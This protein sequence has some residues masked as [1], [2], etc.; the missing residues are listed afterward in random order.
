[1]IRQTVGNNC[2]SLFLSFFATNLTYQCLL[3][4]ILRS[5]VVL[6]EAFYV[7]PVCRKI[8]Y[9]YIQTNLT[10]QDVFFQIT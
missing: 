6:C 10:Y 3:P 4:G 9:T 5:R 2:K 7:M 8:G 1:M